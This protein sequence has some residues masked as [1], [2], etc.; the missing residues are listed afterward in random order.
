MP[1]ELSGA[2][3]KTIYEKKNEK[4]SWHCPFL[5]AD[6][7][8]QVL[9]WNYNLE[10]SFTWRPGKKC[11]SFLPR[12]AGLCLGQKL[13]RL[14]EKDTHTDRHRHRHA[15]QYM[16]PT[17]NIYRKKRQYLIQCGIDSPQRLTVL[18]ILYTRRI[19]FYHT[20]P[21]SV[22]QTVAAPALTNFMLKVTYFCS[23]LSLKSANF[24]ASQILEVEYCLLFNFHLC[25]TFSWFHFRLK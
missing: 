20:D 12:S 17:S 2:Q 3:G 10:C 13:L 14:K 19:F 7:L 4:I 9:A 15:S 1:F 24:Y 6:I 8:N 23:W 18:C 21:S 22:I 11:V 25:W 16:V 5:K